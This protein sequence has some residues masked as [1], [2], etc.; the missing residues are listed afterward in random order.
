MSETKTITILTPVFN[1]EESLGQY[2]QQVRSVIFERP[3]AAED[4]LEYRVLF[5]EDGSRDKSWAMIRDIC[6]EDPRFSGIRLSRNFGSHMAITAGFDHAEGDA[7]CTL[8]CDLQ[9]PP[10]TVLE[11]TREWLAGAR[12]VWGKRRTRKDAGWRMATSRIFFELLRRFAMPRGSKFTTGSFLMVDKTVV[13]CL[14]KFR[15]SNRITFA[16]V[17]W[18]GFDQTTV[19]YDRQVRFAGKSGWTFTRMIKTFYDAFISFS[20]IPVRLITW[21]GMCVSFA[22]LIFLIYLVFNWFSGTPMPGW[23]STMLAMTCFFGLQFLVLGI[24]GEYLQRIHSESL[25]RPLYFVSESTNAQR[26]HG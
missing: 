4:G 5:I 9:D 21:L 19:E 23:T 3:G 8:A 25:G 15:E 12:I 14:R 18:T 24:I 16:L 20:S 26:R 1:E 17:A 10:Q 2:V 7:V 6:R 11:F 22:S 13:E